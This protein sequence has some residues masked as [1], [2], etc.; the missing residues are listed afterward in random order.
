V[1]KD[2]YRYVRPC[3]CRGIEHRV[4]RFNQARLP[5]RGGLRFEDFVPKNAGQQDALSVAET[6]ARKYRPDA[7]SKGF[8]V[9]GPVGSGKTHLLC[10]TLRYLTLEAGA[11]GRYVE[12]SFLFSEIRKGFEERKNGLDA[13]LS[14]V[15]ADV[16]AIDEL[17][18]GRGSPFEMDTL[19]E[20]IARRYNSNRTTL[21]AT[22]FVVDPERATVPRRGDGYQSYDASLAR[23]RPGETLLSERVGERISSRLHEMCHR[24][25]LPLSTE[26]HRK[27]DLPA[28]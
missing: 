20:L 27:Q 15:N 23:E 11:A 14:L 10:A 6:T 2:G 4:H 25:Q 13:I 26:D 22:N 18:K 1:L 7:P 21:F 9:A 12:I 17:G 8:I 5:A 19:D 28:R 3:P 16:L 24:V